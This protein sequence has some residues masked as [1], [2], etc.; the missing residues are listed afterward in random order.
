MAGNSNFISVD[1]H[2]QEHRQVW[3]TRLSR[4]KWGDR[5]P[6]VEKNPN[7]GHRWAV[8]GHELGFDG[9]A[10]CGA[11]MSD[12]TKSPQRWS[13]VP[14]SAYDPRERLKVMDAAGV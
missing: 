11:L 10:D 9:V 5:V 7:G 12:R 3:T 13:D 6:H 1:D 14:A 4:S 8:D 2:V